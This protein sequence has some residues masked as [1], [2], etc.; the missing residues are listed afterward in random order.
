MSVRDLRAGALVRRSS[1]DLTREGSSMLAVFHQPH[2]IDDDMIDPD[3][4]RVDART[5]IRKVIHQ[6][7]RL[8]RDGVR[9]EW[10]FR[11]SSLRGRIDQDDEP[12]RATHGKAD[13]PF[14]TGRR[15]LS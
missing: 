9:F 7:A 13:A 10:Q 12:F 6:L 14:L 2:A 8:G 11:L 4:T 1:D 5:A 3:G 15:T